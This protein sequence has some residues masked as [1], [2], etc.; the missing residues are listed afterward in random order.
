VQSQA[1]IGSLQKLINPALAPE[2]LIVIVFS[3]KLLLSW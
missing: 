2:A 1:N 3:R